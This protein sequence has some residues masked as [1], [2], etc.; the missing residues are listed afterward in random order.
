[1]SGCSSC[2]GKRRRSKISKSLDRPVYDSNRKM[3][4]ESYKKHL[5]KDAQRNRAIR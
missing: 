3:I 2:G 1:M 5:D 4:V